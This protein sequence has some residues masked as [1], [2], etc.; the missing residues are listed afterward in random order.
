MV[1]SLP[2]VGEHAI[3]PPYLRSRDRGVRIR[4]NSQLFSSGGSLA[5]GL[6]DSVLGAVYK[7]KLR[8][9]AVV[10]DS[11]DSSLVG[12]ITDAYWDSSENWAM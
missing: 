8:F 12:R 2:N 3:R 6:I 9:E 7:R 4:P 5:K 1:P 11:A 10:G